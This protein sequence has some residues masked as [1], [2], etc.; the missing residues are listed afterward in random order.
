[1]RWPL[2]MSEQEYVVAGMSMKRCAT[3]YTLTIQSN[4]LLW[5]TKRK[6]NKKNK[7]NNIQEEEKLKKGEDGPTW[8]KKPL[9]SL[10]RTKTTYESARVSETLETT[11][12]TS[13]A[14]RTGRRPY[15]S[16]SGPNV[17]PPS[18][19]PKK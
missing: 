5:R 2:V 16:A 7:K 9:A 19:T 6:M 11:A 3:C 4:D 18:I 13:E 15:F 17:S 10:M 8:R 14:S 12:A 1:M